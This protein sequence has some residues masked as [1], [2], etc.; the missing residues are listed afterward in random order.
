MG[1]ERERGHFVILS[2][3]DTDTIKEASSVVKE[4][5]ALPDS[6]TRKAMDTDDA[7]G[8]AGTVRSPERGCADFCSLS[9]PEATIPSRWP[10]AGCRPDVGGGRRPRP[11]RRRESNSRWVEPTGDAECY[12]RLAG[13]QSR[14]GPYRP[15]TPET[16]R[17]GWVCRRNVGRIL[18]LH[19]R[20]R[21]AARSR[22]RRR[23]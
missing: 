12:L 6:L 7:V 5:M 4:S 15:V 1:K 21:S 18:A 16:G 13:G 14:P 17:W 23:R 8:T 20:G 9:E 22:P 2:D 3:S 10:G 19:R 11:G